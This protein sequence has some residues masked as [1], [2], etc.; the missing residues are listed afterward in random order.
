MI[1]GATPGE[2]VKRRNT[3]VLIFIVGM[4]GFCLGVGLYYLWYVPKKRAEYDSAALKNLISLAAC[5]ERLSNEFADLKFKFPP[6]WLEEHHLLFLKGPYYGW[7]GTDPRADV[8][9]R[10]QNGELSACSRKGSSPRGGS[11][12][13]I[14]RTNIAGGPE[15]PP[16]IDECSGNS[17]AG[18]LCFTESI[19]DPQDGSFRFET[20]RDAE[21]THRCERVLA[22]S[23]GRLADQKALSEK[24]A[25]VFG[26]DLYTRLI[27]PD[28][29]LVVSPYGMYEVLSLLYAGAR[30]DD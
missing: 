13:W 29:N 21:W 15:L 12:R 10:L 23:S 6:P 2:S 11:S 1:E 28:T 5:V 8:R 30:G 17:Y 19:V 9:I 4:I 27:Q 20:K 25:N 26:I 14:Y 22:E 18:D 16:I 7:R 3:P 24:S